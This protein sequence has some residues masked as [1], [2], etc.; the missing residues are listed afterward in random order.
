MRRVR[1]LEGLKI[2]ELAEL[3]EV[4]S[5]TI[6]ALEYRSRRVALETKHKILNALNRRS[7]RRR[8]YIFKDV[9]P[10]EEEI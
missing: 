8:E 9:F 3:A 7:T 5:K 6:Q 10:N 4:S 2:T 1:T